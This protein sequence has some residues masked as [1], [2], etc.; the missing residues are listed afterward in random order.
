MDELSPSGEGRLSFEVSR[1][2]DRSLLVKLHGELD[3]ATADELDTALKPLVDRDTRRLVV[4]ARGLRFA[5]SSAIALFV[6]LANAV[7]EIEIRQPPELLQEVIKRMGLADR[8][9]LVL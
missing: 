5:D 1:E 4:D 2:D 7:G 9:R 6:R 8:L 3:L